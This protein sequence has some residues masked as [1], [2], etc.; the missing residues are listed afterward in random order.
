M[1]VQVTVGSLQLRANNMIQQSFEF[2]A[3]DAKY[4]RLCR[5]LEQHMD[6]SRILVFCE[7]KRGCDDVTR[8]LRQDG[9]PALS[10]HGDKLQ[11]E[12]DW[13]LA[14]RPPRLP[15]DAL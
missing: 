8:R 7:T 10:I 1:C 3:E 14:V 9:W 5:L 12:R 4:S 2:M 6:G 13:V 11:E 15:N